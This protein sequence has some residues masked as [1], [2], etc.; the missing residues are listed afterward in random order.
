MKKYF[1][2]TKSILLVIAAGILVNGCTKLDEE[3]YSE[4][5]ASNFDATPNDVPSLIAPVYTNLRGMV[6]SWQG[7]F[8]VQEE[9]AD[10]IVTPA[11]PNGWVDGGTYQRMHQHTWNAT[12]GQ[13]NGVYT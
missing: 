13:P 7:Y 1:I 9:A 10:A 12:Q 8:D 4:L 6:A 11:R 5:L 2:N 3:V